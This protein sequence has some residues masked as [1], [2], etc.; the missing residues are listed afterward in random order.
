MPAK[1]NDYRV[2]GRILNKFKKY[3]GKMFKIIDFNF[4]KYYYVTHVITFLRAFQI[5][6]ILLCSKINKKK[7]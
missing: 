5:Y 2:Q 6:K 3:V 4:E 1:F 7:Y